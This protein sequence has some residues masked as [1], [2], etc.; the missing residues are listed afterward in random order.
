M[1]SSQS[2][3]ISQRMERRDSA[4]PLKNNYFRAKKIIIVLLVVAFCAG[5]Y[6]ANAQNSDKAVLLNT[7][8]IRSDGAA[9]RAARDL[10]VRVG[11]RK[12]E[13]WYKLPAGYLATYTDQ[14]GE[15]RFVYDHKGKWLYSIC[16]CTE[17]Q[18]PE[19]VRRLIRSTYYDFTIGW[20]KEIKQDESIVYAV[21]IESEKQWMDLMV[22]DG[23]VRELK[24][25]SKQ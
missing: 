22:Q 11:D 13:S 21:H 15:S 24:S 14:R 17:K 2:I 19:E 1:K 25:F 23:E 8:A 12:E 3:I 7:H 9:V 16:T 5:S 4:R 18:M 20:V 10:W 6:S